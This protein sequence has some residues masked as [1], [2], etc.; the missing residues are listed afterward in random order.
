MQPDTGVG[1]WIPG[2][3][4]SNSEPS[5]TWPRRAAAQY[6]LPHL[7]GALREKKIEQYCSELVL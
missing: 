6:E 4:V 1:D 5:M 7:N 3:I 2:V